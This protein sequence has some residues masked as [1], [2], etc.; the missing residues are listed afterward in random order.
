MPDPEQPPGPGDRPV[1]RSVALAIRAPDA[2]RVLLVRRPPDDA[3][4]PGVW[5]LPAASLAPGETWAAA[6]A[7][8]AREKLGV[9]IT[10]GRMLRHGE[11][12]RPDYRL[13]MRLYEATIA[14]GEPAVPQPRADVTQYAAWRWGEPAEVG[15][16]AARGS[17]C[18]RLLLEATDA[19]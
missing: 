1:K 16:G 3:E 8:A 12:A 18:C 5:G 17:L 19:A 9:E 6:A 10:L 14:A 13:E 11:Q 15:P 2:A 4:L 7:R